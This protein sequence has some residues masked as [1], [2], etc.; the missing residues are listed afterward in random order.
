MSEDQG[1]QS[2]ESLKSELAALEK[3]AAETGSS[4]ARKRHDIYLNLATVHRGSP[5]HSSNPEKAFQ[6]MLEA[7]RWAERFRS[8]F[9]TRHVTDEFTLTYMLCMLDGLEVWTQ[10]NKRGS[11]NHDALDA[12][13]WAA[14]ADRSRLLLDRLDQNS[15]LA[16]RPSAEERPPSASSELVSGLSQQKEYAGTRLNFGSKKNSTSTEQ[17]I[18]AD[19]LD[20]LNELR[21]DVMVSMAKLHA[22]EVPPSKNPMV[23][24]GREAA[25]LIPTD[26]P[27]VFVHFTWSAPRPV[28]LLMGRDER[29]AYVS[30]TWLS[31][32][33]RAIELYEEW[34]NKYAEAVGKLEGPSAGGRETIEY[35][36]ALHRVAEG[37]LS[38][39]SKFALW[40]VLSKLRPNIER[41]VFFPN[42]P[43]HA[44][45]FHACPMDDGRPLADRYEIMYAPSLSVFARNCEV[46]ASGSSG[47]LVQPP[48]NLNFCRLES[49]VVAKHIRQRFDL[50]VM[51]GERASRDTLTSGILARS[52]FIHYCGHSVFDREQPEKSTLELCGTPL[53][54]GEVFHR[55]RTP[56]NLLTVLTGCES[57]M[58]FPDFVDDHESF[59][60][61]FLAA[62]ARCVISAAWSVPDFSTALLMDKFY[63]GWARGSL[64]PAS[65]LHAA[66]KWLR[67][68]AAGQE[69]DLAVRDLA[70]RCESPE[71]AIEA[72][73]KE[74][75]TF[76]DAFG[77]R[78]FQSPVHWAGFSCHGA[79]HIL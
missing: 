54:L 24:N 39:V 13:I 22:L 17:A 79:G 60:M 19:R 42:G 23:V 27:T 53:T 47:I 57:G 78:P 52:R 65:A 29:G 70:S 26:R 40:P 16:E 33:R 5:L 76:V 3:R 15:R 4:Y 51:A 30:T 12:A 59:S 75:T 28:I 7:C 34:L 62:G 71:T 18:P 48:S 35:C 32:P 2:E 14:E 46:S 43:L 37:V 74:A 50:E 8:E 66:Q 25:R 11:A 56:R 73:S 10:S 64:S 61:A 1:E 58:M 55:I 31:D 68:L 21:D 49:E 44:F 67:S 63:E 9:E 45:P 69:M 36:A 20:Y 72:L 77:E 41:L 38:K 6:C